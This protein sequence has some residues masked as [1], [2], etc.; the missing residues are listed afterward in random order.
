M[1]KY[2]NRWTDGNEIVKAATC[3]G[4][5]YYPIYAQ[6]RV[7]GSTYR[8]YEYVAGSLDWVKAVNRA[9]ASAARANWEQK[10]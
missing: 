3:P 4:E 2:S 1:T 9:M 10:R 6:W 5:Y 8:P 7:H